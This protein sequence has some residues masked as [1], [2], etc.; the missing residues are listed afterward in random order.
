L[1]YYFGYAGTSE[2]PLV[3]PAGLFIDAND[4]IFV[5]DSAARRLQVFHYYGPAQA[6]GGTR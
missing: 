2:R 1:L 3:S 6:Q 4:R 5:V